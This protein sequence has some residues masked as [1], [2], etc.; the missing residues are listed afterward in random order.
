MYFRVRRGFEDETFQRADGINEYGTAI[1]YEGV[2]PVNAAVGFA[3]H[4]AGLKFTDESLKKYLRSK[5][6][7]LDSY[8]DDDGNSFYSPKVSKDLVELVGDFILLIDTNLDNRICVSP[9]KIFC[10]QYDKLDAVLS[11]F[12]SVAGELYRDGLI[13]AVTENE[14][15]ADFVFN[16]SNEEVAFKLLKRVEDQ[17]NPDALCDIANSYYLG[18]GAKQ[19]YKLAKEY[20]ERAI[21]HGSNESRF[22]LATMYMDGYGVKKCYNRALCLLVEAIHFGS[23]KA[24]EYLAIDYLN[25]N[26]LKR[27]EYLAYSYAT[28]GRSLNSITCTRLLAELTLKGVGCRADLAKALVYYDELAEDD[29]YRLLGLAEIYYRNREFG[30]DDNEISNMLYRSYKNGLKS[31]G[32]LLYRLYSDSNIK[33]ARERA[34]AYY[35]EYTNNSSA[36]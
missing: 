17:N 32:E 6:I 12:P 13:E 34:L 1:L 33:E 22:C 27:N 4:L 9:G 25:G 11:I 10:L 5:N 21:E 28:I 31:S 7:E 24:C 23:E 2:I 30:V 29:P 18:I 36:S 15:A 3:K 14:E 35:E 16:G 26:H 8:L 20:Y 19:S